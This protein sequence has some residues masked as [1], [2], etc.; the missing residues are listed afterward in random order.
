[1]IFLGEA[2]LRHTVNEYMT[3]YHAERNHQGMGNRLLKPITT[4]SSVRHGS[5]NQRPRLGGMLNYYYREAA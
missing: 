3:H 5:V 1:M 4:T 2:S